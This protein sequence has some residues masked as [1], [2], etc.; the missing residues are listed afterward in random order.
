LSSSVAGISSIIECQ[1]AS[2][3]SANPFAVI[4]VMLSLRFLILVIKDRDT[5]TIEAAA[6]SLFPCINHRREEQMQELIQVETPRDVFRLQTRLQDLQVVF[7][8]EPG[9]GDQT[10]IEVL[11]TEAIG[12]RLEGEAATS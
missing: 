9:D 11:L 1:V 10:I 2:R 3:F 12:G 6:A 5:E 4:L 8:E 7:E